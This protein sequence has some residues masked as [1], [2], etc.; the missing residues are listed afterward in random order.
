MER[1]DIKPG[2]ISH[3]H[4][5]HVD[6]GAAWD[7]ARADANASVGSFGKA[8]KVLSYSAVDPRLEGKLLQG[9]SVPLLLAAGQTVSYGDNIFPL[10]PRNARGQREEYHYT[11]A[12]GTH[13]R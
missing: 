6:M 8:A 3:A 9:G 10:D 12:I 7:N 13:R 5:A 11:P 1:V 2:N 4:F